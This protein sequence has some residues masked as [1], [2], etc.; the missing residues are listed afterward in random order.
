MD[1]LAIPY[2]EIPQELLE[3]Q[4]QRLQ[5][6][7]HERGGEREFQFLRR[8][9]QP[10]LPVWQAGQLRILPWGCQSRVLPRSGLTWLRTVE[11]G[12]WGNHAVERVEIPASLGLQNG[13]WYRIRR[14]VQG[15]VVEAQ[16]IVA[17]YVIVEPASYY[18][19][20]MTRCEQMPLLLG[21]KI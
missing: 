7:L 18:Y 16:G 9:R 12:A 11:E 15:L 14:G 17:T 3:Q 8:V 13:V 6:C 5:S 1:G 20:I 2:S 10:I 4:Q 19:R 21:E